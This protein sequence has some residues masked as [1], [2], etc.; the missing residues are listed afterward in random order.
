[1]HPGWASQVLVLHAGHTSYGVGREPTFFGCKCLSSVDLP[2]LSSPTTMMLHAFFDHPKA[3][4]IIEKSPMV[5]TYSYAGLYAQRT[6][7]TNHNT[8]ARA[9]RDAMPVSKRP[10]RGAHGHLTRGVI[11][12]QRAC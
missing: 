11:R 12:A 1:M 3:L 2:L 6:R 4:A 7:Y 5:P 10:V 9:H 8:H